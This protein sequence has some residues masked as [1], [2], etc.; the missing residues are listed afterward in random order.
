VTGL[1]AGGGV[2]TGEHGDGEDAERRAGRVD[3][4]P[5][6]G[7]AGAGVHGDEAGP[8]GAGA[9]DG[10]DHG[11]GDVVQLEVE[12]DL[13]L[14]VSA[15]ELTDDLGALSDEQ[16]EAHLEHADVAGEAL[17][18]GEGGGGVG[19]VERDDQ[20]PT[21]RFQGDGLVHGGGA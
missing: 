4:G 7:D 6:V 12:E 15:A 13:Q 5:Q 20:A 21:R 1:G 10:A 19:D 18:G 14:W 2:L 17:R 3:A 8:E 9:A 11:V 16:L